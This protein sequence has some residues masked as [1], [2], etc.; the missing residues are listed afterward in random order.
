M[1]KKKVSSHTST[2]M[3][4]NLWKKFIILEKYAA[5]NKTGEQKKT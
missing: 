3:P 1:F 4:T 2:R 5:S